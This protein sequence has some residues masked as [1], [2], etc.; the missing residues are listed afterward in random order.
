MVPTSENDFSAIMT[1]P[2]KVIEGFHINK[3]K[4]PILKYF[5]HCR[6]GKWDNPFGSWCRMDYMNRKATQIPGYCAGFYR[7]KF[8]AN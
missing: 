7:T 2:S 1:P 6:C 3:G 4:N 8:S 5:K